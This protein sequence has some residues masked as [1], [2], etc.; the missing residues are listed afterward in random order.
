ML[1]DMAMSAIDTIREVSFPELN[2]IKYSLVEEKEEK[3]KE[4]GKDQIKFF[5]TT[6]SLDLLSTSSSSNC[7]ADIAFYI[8]ECHKQLLE[9][10]PEA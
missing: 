2:A 3:S 1:S 8:S 10:P 7:F 9:I 6:Y 5:D 4:T